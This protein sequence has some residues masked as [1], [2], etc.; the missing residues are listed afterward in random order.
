ME[1]KICMV[2]GA[3]AGIGKAT[4]HGLAEMG[5][6]VI[7]VGRNPEKCARVV[8]EIRKATRN[9][10]VDCLLA[11]LTDLSQIHRL[12]LHF[13]ESYPRLHVLINNAGAIF[14]T[15][16]E[17]VD[18]IEMTFALNHLSYFLLTLLLLDELKA[19]APSRVVNVS[20]N[21]HFGKRLNFD[22][23]QSERGY[24]FMQVYG[25]SK[26]ANLYFTFELARRLDGTGVTVNALH[27]GFVATD[28]GK[29]NGLLA[30][31]IVP[32]IHFRSLTPEQGAQTSLYLASSP[33]V[34]G[35]S[36]EYFVKCKIGHV[37]PIARDPEAARRL[38]RTSA[39]LT[40]MD[41]WA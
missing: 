17:T 12:A 35:I 21:G 25:R 22:D 8:E 27:P 16:R 13:Q 24:K 39:E 3:T 20:S 40:G 9:Q 28:M 30:R 38:W 18:G 6:K 4:A 14:L 32:L 7:V 34:K 26:L 37:D 15:R 11:D 2:T 5:A 31:L 1:G 33:D 23:L 29:N 36:G 19:S 41:N 10:N